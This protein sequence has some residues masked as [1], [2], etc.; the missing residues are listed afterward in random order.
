MRR[1]QGQ[2][3]ICNSCPAGKRSVHTKCRGHFRV[4]FPLLLQIKGDYPISGK[5]HWL[6]H[7][8]QFWEVTI[9]GKTECLWACKVNCCLGQMPTH[10]LYSL[11]KEV[12]WSSKIHW[13]SSLQVGKDV[14]YMNLPETPHAQDLR[15]SFFPSLAQALGCS[16]SFDYLE[17]ESLPPTTLL[18][19]QSCKVRKCYLYLP[20]FSLKA[21]DEFGD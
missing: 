10:C 6:S 7:C 21:E 12:T 4:V 1:Q 13:L 19:G 11:L 17:H 8:N 16:G 18:P 3:F 14:S 2:P 15:A 5:L 20:Q 9:C